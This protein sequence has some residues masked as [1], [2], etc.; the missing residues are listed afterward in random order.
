MRFVFVLLLMQATLVEVHG[1][2]YVLPNEEQVFS[3]K[4]GN[5]KIAVLCKDKKDQYLVYRFGTNKKPELVFPAST[6]SGW[7]AFRYSYYMRGGGPQN[8]G[9]DLNYVYFV[10]KGY[11]YVIYDTYHAVGGKRKVGVKV[12]D[13][14]TDKVTDIVGLVS[15]AKGNLTQFRDNKRLLVTDELFD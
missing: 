14:Q 4:T 8:E 15:S 10:S 7:E 13:L 11:K 5:G 6:K 3:F 2:Q 12:I 1:Q 9:M